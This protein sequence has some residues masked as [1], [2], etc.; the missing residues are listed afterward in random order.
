MNAMNLETKH[1]INGREVK[2][3]STSERIALIAAV[4]AQIS[5]L[6]GITT[7]AGFIDAEIAK[8]EAFLADIVAK[9]DAEA[10]FID[11]G[12]T[13]AEASLAAIVAG[14]DGDMA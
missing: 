11:A 2:S 5:K 12:T 7:K 13:K 1:F 4:E 6:K 10:G 3:Y 9:F 8:A 14:I